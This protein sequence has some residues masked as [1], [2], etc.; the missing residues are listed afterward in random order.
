M[1]GRPGSRHQRPKRRL[2]PAS[3]ATDGGQRPVR[4]A[5]GGC[6]RPG[7]GGRGPGL[8]P[9]T[10]AV[11]ASVAVAGGGCGR[12]QTAWDGD[13]NRLP[14]PVAGPLR[15]GAPARKKREGLSA[16]PLGFRACRV[17]RAGPVSSHRRRDRR[18]SRGGRCG[19]FPAPGSRSGGRVPWRCRA[20]CPAPPASH[21]RPAGGARG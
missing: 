16:I 15:S 17:R 4:R 7:A 10:G 18:W 9:V 20:W 8:R 14:A 13:G 11:A 5:V 21:R 19:A 6:R 3:G 12:G 1:P 2:A